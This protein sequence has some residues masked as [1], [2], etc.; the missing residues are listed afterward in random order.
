MYSVFVQLDDGEFQHVASRNDL[1]QA[2]H[3]VEA[4]K[5]HWPH[6]Y[7][8]RDSEGGDVLRLRISDEERYARRGYRPRR[9]C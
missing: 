9:R 1:E 3:L 4:F 2:I 5:T 7:V 6:E 8:V